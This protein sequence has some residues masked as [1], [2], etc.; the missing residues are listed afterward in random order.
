[1]DLDLEVLIQEFLRES[2]DGLAAM[3]EA[4][5]A[6]EADATAERLGTVFR[7]AHTLKGNALAVG[8]AGV[9]ELSH[10]LEDLLSKMREGLLEAGPEC[11][12]L[13][14]QLCELFI[15]ILQDSP[16]IRR[17]AGR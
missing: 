10:V 9:A 8:F 15:E 4:L 7:I 12:T 1:M 17:E 2:E 3:E 16:F 5:I 14:L 6:L 13:L 11:I